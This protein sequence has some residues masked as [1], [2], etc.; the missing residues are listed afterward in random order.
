MADVEQLH[1][2]VL[3]TPAADAPRLAYA[4]AIQASDPDRAELIRTQVALTRSLQQRMPDGSRAM[5]YSKLRNLVNHHGA[6]WMKSIRDLGYV[7]DPVMLRGFVEWVTLSAQDF[8]EHGDDVY[9]CA[10]VLHVDLTN[11]K[12]HAEALFASPLLDRIHSLGLQENQLGDHELKLLAGSPHL[13]QLR[14]LDLSANEIGPAGVDA[15]AASDQLPSLRYVDVRDNPVP[16]PTPRP[17]EGDAQTAT[18]IET[19]SAGIALEQRFGKRAWLSA[20][21]LFPYY[22]PARGVL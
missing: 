14:F 22:P 6:R 15:L 21:A 16:D 12:P 3:T 17:T 5:M 4:D 9:A 13:G 7:Q 8:L 2:D 10:P 20:E 1:A 11:V 19:P 18:R